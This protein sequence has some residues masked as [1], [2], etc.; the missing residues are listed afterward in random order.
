MAKVAYDPLI[1]RLVLH[2]HDEMKV[3][4]L[5]L[6]DGNG[7]EWVLTVNTDGALVTT[8]TAVAQGNPFGPWLWLTYP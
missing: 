3:N 1:N 6:V 2:D 5:T 7:I 8:Q 4:S